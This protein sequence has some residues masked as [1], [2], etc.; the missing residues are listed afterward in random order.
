MAIVDKH[1]DTKG[2]HF[3]LS[4]RVLNVPQ[5]WQCSAAA[6]ASNAG[7]T[8]SN[9]FTSSAKS[10]TFAIGTNPDLPRNALVKLTPNTASSSLYSAG[11]IILH[12]LDVFGS[13]R[14]ES[15]AVTAL[16]TVS[17][18]LAG[19]V[20]FKQI[21]T[22]SATVVL[23]TASSANG[24]NVSLHIGYGNVINIPVEFKSTNAVFG[25]Y[26]GTASKLGS[27]YTHTDSTSL[28]KYSVAT[29]PYY[30]AGVYMVDAVATNT[31]VRVDFTLMGFSAPVHDSDW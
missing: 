17:A 11:S 16:N 29:G 8:T 9:Y 20:C 1:I 3:G 2:P 24:S 31:P 25:V 26:L 14:S 22:L 15:F 10:G 12:G 23:H 21:D 18:G 30:K 13:S 27:I 5:Q 7:F 19:Q 6:S 4:P 28:N